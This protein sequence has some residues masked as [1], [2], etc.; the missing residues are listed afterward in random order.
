MIDWEDHG[1]FDG[2]GEVG[3]SRDGGR[4]WEN[5]RVFAR[6]KESA[7]ALLPPDPGAV[8]LLNGPWRF[9]L[10]YCPEQAPRDFHLPAFDDS[11]W[12][13]IAVPGAWDLQGHG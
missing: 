10:A 6:G 12:T 13:E 4:D 1:F 8:C 7:H 5:Q 9:Q 3:S 2:R 11:D